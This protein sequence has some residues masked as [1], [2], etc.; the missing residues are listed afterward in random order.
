MSVIPPHF[1]I[2]SEPVANPGSIV[3][4]GEARFTVLTERLIRMEFSPQGRFEDRPSQIFW[5]RRQPAPKFTVKQ[6]A[7][8]EIITP[9][10]HLKYRSGK[11][12]AP[13]TLSVK[14]K[15]MG[16]AWNYGDEDAANLKGTARTLDAVDGITPLETGLLSREGWVVVD[17]S[18][19]LVFNED[20]WLEGRGTDADAKDL[21][22]FGYGHD[23]TACLQEFARVSGPAP[24]VPRFVLGNWWSRYWEYSDQELGALMLKFQEKKIP[25]SVC[26]IDMDWHITRTGNESSGW[27]GY[28][29]NRKFFH[30]PQGFI[31]FLHGLELKTALNLH[32]AEGLH[33]HEEQYPAM[34]KAMGIDPASKQPVKFDLEN[35][36]FLNPYLDIL[37]HP[38]EEMGIDFW[39]MDWQQG[40]P[41]RLPGLNL[42]WWINHIHFYDLGREKSKRGMVFS[43]WGG[44]GNHRYPI[45]FSGDTFVTWNTLAFQPYFTATA[46]NVGYGWWS[47]DIG[48][49]NEGIEDPELYT[50]W[51]QWGVFSPIFRLHS[52]KNMFHQRLPWGYNPSVEQAAGDAMRFRHALIPYLYSMAWRNYSQGLPLVRPM[53][54]LQPECEEAYACPNQYAFG[55]ELVVAPF[56]APRDPETRLSRSVV[57]LPEGDWFDFF[58]GNYYPGDAWHAV[59]GKL[60]DIP[61]FARAGALVPLAPSPEWSGV[62]NPPGMTLHIFPGADNRFELFEDDGISQD[63]L[64]GKYAVTEITQEWTEERQTVR[65]LV[66]GDTSSL[67]KWRT[68][69][70]IFHACS[71]PT[72]VTVKINGIEME[73][74]AQY[75]MKRKVLR[76]RLF[77]VSLADELTVELLKN[78]SLIENKVNR[79]EFKNIMCIA[80][81]TFE[82]DDNLSVELTGKGSLAVRTDNRLERVKKLIWEANLNNTCKRA[83]HNSLNAWLERPEELGRF[84]LPLSPLLKRALFEIITGAGVEQITST[85]EEVIVVWNNHEDSRITYGLYWE[86]LDMFHSTER[87]HQEKAI[88]P[89]FRAYRPAVDFKGMD[90]RLKVD[91]YDQLMVKIE[92]RGGKPSPHATLEIS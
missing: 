26:I 70:L 48:G 54:H 83:M 17:D 87:Y 75:Y 51:V 49:H 61:V 8:L 13:E 45:G 72:S 19:G 65:L 29:W 22:F 40:N 27:T 28:T 46:A 80:E 62:G 31:E 21:Y 1:K 18:C 59:Y 41:T 12:F 11:D 77:P 33:P 82:P 2:T 85:G 69:E 47:H 74:S 6:G 7:T 91:F 78:G 24:V 71:D 84:N 67:P 50:R 68:W 57:W 55:S 4:A 76:L 32:P 14:V 38:Q 5:F 20:G 58:E 92:H 64:A 66:T 34:A 81:Y 52:T 3:T 39:W 44:L 42:L 15:A 9:Y 16:T 25:L 43:R 79:R 63:Y 56:I 36:D 35:P 60:E 23:Y 89:K 30:D 90:A 86:I 53:Y 73:A 10:L 37:H 88:A